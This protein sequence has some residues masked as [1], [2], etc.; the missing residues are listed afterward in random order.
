[1]FRLFFNIDYDFKNWTFYIS[2]YCDAIYEKL[3]VA[4]FT[5]FCYILVKVWLPHADVKVLQLGE[6]QQARVPNVFDLLVDEV[7]ALACARSSIDAVGHRILG[8]LSSATAARRPD[9]VLF[10]DLLEFVLHWIN[11]LQVIV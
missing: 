1:M 9:D 11:L 10:E 4:A 2:V 8:S 7:R 6:H 5:N 3:I